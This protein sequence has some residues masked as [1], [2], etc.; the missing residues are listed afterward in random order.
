MPQTSR[1]GR[2]IAGY[3]A[4]SGK[5]IQR[6]A[7]Y[8]EANSRAL[9]EA[10]GSSRVTGVL[11]LHLTSSS[12]NGVLDVLCSLTPGTQ[13]ETQLSAMQVHIKSFVQLQIELGSVIIFPLE[14]KTDLTEICLLDMLCV[15][16]KEN[17]PEANI[18][19]FA[20]V[21]KIKVMYLKSH[22]LQWKQSI[23]TDK[24]AHGHTALC[25]LL[26]CYT[27]QTAKSKWSQRRIQQSK[28]SKMN[29]L[30]V[31]PRL[32]DGEQAVKNQIAE[33]K[34]PQEGSDRDAD[35]ASILG[36]AC[37]SRHS[38]IWTESGQAYGFGNNFYAQL[39]YDFQ[40]ADFKEHQVQYSMAIIVY[41][42]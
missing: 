27:I 34:L 29:F 20:V 16:C 36:V 41:L 11:G 7:F 2:G 38:F 12:W 21:V 32:G 19:V 15:L 8:Q 6:G 10:A 5:Q 30:S 40:R 9:F 37:G 42:Q 18:T 14:C 1:Y 25:A 23:D 35:V 4:G 33:V 26:L 39:G 3:D 28:L 22:V 31:F 13:T 24:Y 17:I